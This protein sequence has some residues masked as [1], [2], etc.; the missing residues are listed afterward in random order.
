MKNYF[1]QKFNNENM[2][3]II[4][5]KYN[6]HPGINNHQGKEGAGA[7]HDDKPEFVYHFMKSSK[8]PMMTNL[9]FLPFNKM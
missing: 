5:S 1:I 2:R 6:L 4:H 8:N 9:R 3:K 7:T